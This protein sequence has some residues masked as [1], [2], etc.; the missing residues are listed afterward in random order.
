VNFSDFEGALAFFAELVTGRILNHYFHVGCVGEGTTTESFKEVFVLR[1]L[2]FLQSDD[3]P[4]R[5][6]LDW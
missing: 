3:F 4:I 1:A 6:I 2:L 5:D